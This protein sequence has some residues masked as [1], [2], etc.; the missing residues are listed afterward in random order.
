LRDKLDAK[1]EYVGN[2]L[3]MQGF[4]NLVKRYLKSERLRLKMRY[5]SGDIANPVHVQPA[6][7][8]RL[9]HYWGIEKQV[10][11]STK[12]VDAHSKVKRISV[13]ERKGKAGQQALAVSA[14]VPLNLH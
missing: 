9:K 1:F 13:V 11:K 8:E 14:R 5:R 3:S 2:P 10:L 6:Q 4:R 7:W 12:M